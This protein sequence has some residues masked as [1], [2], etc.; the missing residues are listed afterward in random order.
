MFGEE[1]LDFVDI[2][3]RA[4]SYLE[5]V[6]LAAE[7]NVPMI[8]QKLQPDLN[9]QYALRSLRQDLSM[10]GHFLILNQLWRDILEEIRDIRS[11]L[12]GVERLLVFEFLDVRDYARIFNVLIQLIPDIA[13]LLVSRFHKLVHA[14]Q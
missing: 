1:E 2:V 6:T 5:L 14:F 9:G 13:R 11:A 12:V 10:E 4:D 3:T 7:Q 8:C